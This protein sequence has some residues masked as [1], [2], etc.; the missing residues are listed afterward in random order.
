MAISSY[1]QVAQPYQRKTHGDQNEC[2]V[3]FGTGVLISCDDCPNSYHAEC[4]G[5]KEHLPRGKWKCYFCK[6]VTHGLTNKV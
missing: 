2:V 4:L 3:C 6:V 5:Y 1:T